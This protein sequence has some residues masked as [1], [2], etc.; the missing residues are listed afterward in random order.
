M[1]GGELTLGAVL[2]RLEER[3]GEIAAQA[4]AAK[5]QIAQLTA[6]LNELD[7]AAEEVRIMRKTLLE[8]PDPQLSA[9]PAPKLPDH[10]AYQQIMAVF[11]A[12]DHPLR[13]R[14]VCEAMDL[15]VA[16]N[17]INNIRLKLKR[18]TDRGILAETEQGL[19]TQPRP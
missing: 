16:P 8:L 15:T 3:E 12:A 9:A 4:E 18:L 11:T 5:E 10:P 2:A 19:F 1:T 17:N 6:Q 14:Q 7:R 13:A